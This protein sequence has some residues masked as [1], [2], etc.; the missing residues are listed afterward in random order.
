ML[1]D[2]I[3]KKLK[4]YLNTD[5]RGNVSPS[6]FNVLLH[7]AIL[8]RNEEYNYELNRLV[9]KENR[10]QGSNLSENLT[11]KIRDKIMH[12][13]TSR[14]LA[15]DTPSVRI[16]PD[17]YRFMDEVEYDNGTT[18]EFCRDRRE[19]NIIKT[20]ATKQYP[21]YTKSGNNLRIAPEESGLMTISYL[22]TVLVPKWTFTVVNGTELFNPSANDFQDADIHPSE[23][24]EIVRILLASF[25]INLKES[26]VSSFATNEQ[27]TDFNKKN[28]N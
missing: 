17:D 14:T 13:H 21:V 12:Y 7:N 24:D 23:E 25:G 5:L 27:N 2:R 9:T 3:Y 11:D 15:I 20:I 4:S 22:R 18:L 6:E 19:F 26:D 28:S 16:L 1:I 8:A 10:G